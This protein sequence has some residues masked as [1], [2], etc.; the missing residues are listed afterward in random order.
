MLIFLQ[1][2]RQARTL[3]PNPFNVYMNDL[4]VEVEEENHGVTMGEDTVS[5]FTFCG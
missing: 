1:G 4:I 2:V 5:G 3:S